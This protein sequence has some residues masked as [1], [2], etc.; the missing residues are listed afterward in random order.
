VSPWPEARALDDV[1]EVDDEDHIESSGRTLLHKKDMQHKHH[2][3]HIEW[4]EDDVWHP[5]ARDGRHDYCRYNWCERGGAVHIAFNRCAF[6]V[7]TRFQTLLSNASTCT[8]TAR[9]LVLLQAPLL[10][11]LRWARWARWV[12]TS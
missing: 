9:Q 2:G 8:T 10:R 3:H 12:C 4:N 1:K 6:E 5:H 11:E 7:K